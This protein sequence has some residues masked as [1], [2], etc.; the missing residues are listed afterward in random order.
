MA[1]KYNSLYDYVHADTGFGHTTS[2]T[3]ISASN[4]SQEVLKNIVAQEG[5]AKVLDQRADSSSNPTKLKY[6]AQEIR[7]RNQRTLLSDPAIKAIVATGENVSV[8][9]EYGREG[10]FLLT[11]TEAMSSTNPLPNEIIDLRE[12]GVR[13]A[14][15]PRNVTE[16]IHES[17]RLDVQRETYHRSAVKSDNKFF[18]LIKEII[19][20]DNH[21]VEHHDL[22]KEYELAENRANKLYKENKQRLVNET[23]DSLT[24]VFPVS[25]GKIAQIAN[26]WVDWMNRKETTTSYFDNELTQELSAPSRHSVV[27]A[28]DFW[29]TRVETVSLGQSNWTREA[30][31]ASSLRAE[32]DELIERNSTYEGIQESSKPGLFTWFTGK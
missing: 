10:Q 9:I 1:T 30:E 20:G 15:G 24:S 6:L 2:E 16:A 21:R 32:A 25:S 19:T 12:S 17:A 27:E 18:R 3:V 26:S 29:G 23:T 28:G 4:I 8:N 14:N 7:S 5:A 13:V 22:V 31:H 11:K